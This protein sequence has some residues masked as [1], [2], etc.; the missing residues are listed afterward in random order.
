MYLQVKDC[1][2]WVDVSQPQNHQG[3]LTKLN[4]VLLMHG[5]PDTAALWRDQIAALLAAGY[6]VFAPDMPGYGK[7]SFRD[8]Q[9]LK[10]YSLRNIVSVM[11]GM[12]DQLGISRAAVVGHDWGAAV[13]WAFASQAPQRV[14]RLVV[15]SVGHPG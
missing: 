3:S 13:A 14:T 2:I 15:L 4:W 1:Q 10:Q 6:A 8:P 7:S 5:F 9:D 11:C 12:L